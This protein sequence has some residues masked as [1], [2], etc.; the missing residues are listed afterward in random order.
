MD[1]DAKTYAEVRTLKGHAGYVWKVAFSPD[2]RYLA[3]GKLGLD[4]EALGP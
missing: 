1:W 3:S 4:V 2:G